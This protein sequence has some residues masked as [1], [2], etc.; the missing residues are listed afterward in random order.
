VPSRTAPARLRPISS[1]PQSAKPSVTADLPTNTL[2]CAS[3]G[4]GAR[5]VAQKASMQCASA[6]APVCAV[7]T[8]GAPADSSGSTIAVC[9][10]RCG[11]ETPT[12]SVRS[13]SV[14]TA[15]GVTSEPVPAVVG[16]ATTGS[17]GPGT[18]S[19]P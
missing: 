16:T 7:S 4:A 6:S 14:T 19:S 13:A 9:G 18:R 5:V 2:S 15:T 8:G 11:L 12:L 1:A 17:T 3:S 10:M